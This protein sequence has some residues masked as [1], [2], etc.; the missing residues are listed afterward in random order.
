MQI[1]IKRNRCLKP[2][3]IKLRRTLFYEKWKEIHTGYKFFYE[4]FNKLLFYHLPC[5]NLWASINVTNFNECKHHRRI[6]NCS[7]SWYLTQPNPTLPYPGCINK[8]NNA[9]RLTWICSSSW[10]L[11]DLSE[12][13]SFW[14]LSR[15][16][17]SSLRSSCRSPSSASNFRWRFSNKTLREVWNEKKFQG[18]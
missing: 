4:F 6:R 5:L 2:E 17:A 3:E 10:Y 16:A 15:A 11:T 7:S 13:I 18:S 8:C 12:S 9:H 14:S 1:V